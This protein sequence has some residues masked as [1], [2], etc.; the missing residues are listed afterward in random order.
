M[1]PDRTTRA[2]ACGER[3]SVPRRDASVLVGPTIGGVLIQVVGVGWC[4]AVDVTGLVTAVGVCS[5]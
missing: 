3:R 1:P 5:S 2:V 4:Y